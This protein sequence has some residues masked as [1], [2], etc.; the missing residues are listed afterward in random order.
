MDQKIRLDTFL[1]EQNLATSRE[2]ARTLI[3]ARLVKVDGIIAEKPA[4]LVS[5]DNQVD[6]Q[7]KDHPFVSRGGLKLE[8]AFDVFPL[9]VQ[10][11]VCVD[12]GAS[13][14]G[15]TDC[16]LQHG[17]KKVYSID[18]GYGQL[19]WSLRQNPAV[20]SM[21][22]QNA[23]FIQA[24]WFDSNDDITFACMD[25]AFISIRKILVPLYD[26]LEENAQV[27]ALI[28]PQFE[29]GREHVGKKGVVRDTAV[30][31]DVIM[32][33]LCFVRDNHYSIKGL[34]F[35]PITGPQGNI[36]FL[37]WLSKD[38]QSAWKKEYD[39]NYAMDIA[40]IAKESLSS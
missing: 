13:T 12:V 16:L 10:D 20:V 4:M 39:A 32:E 3:Q 40:K 33:I 25:L 5:C 24:D 8:K 2:K 27:I 38:E 36:E 34:D 14:G 37:L 21:E 18:V 29:A 19:D 15:F 30:H 26:C 22:R 1:V 28:K 11:Q 6:I 35:S 9:E 31:Y 7:G 17:A 23:R